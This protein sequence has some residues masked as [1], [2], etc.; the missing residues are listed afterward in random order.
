VIDMGLWTV[1]KSGGMLKVSPKE[2]D[3]PSEPALARIVLVAAVIAGASYMATW[4]LGLSPGLAIL[5]KGAGVGLLALYAAL[6][7]RSIDGWLVAGVMAFGALGDVL[8][9]TSGLTVGAAAFLVGHLI[10]IGLYLRKRRPGGAAQ[11]AAIMLIPITMA[12]AFALPAD[13]QLALSAAA[14]SAGLGGM[15]AAAWISRFPRALTGLGALMFLV[16]DL[17]I[18]ARAGPLS[19]VAWVGFAVWVFYFAGQLLIVLGVTR[20]LAAPLAASDDALAASP[21]RVR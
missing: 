15:A 19:D 18:F 2:P 11:L 12:A 3:L 10:A 17:L 5:W 20:T 6:R 4:D 21:V 7:A 13:R 8:L 16:S 14:Y 1:S 9:E